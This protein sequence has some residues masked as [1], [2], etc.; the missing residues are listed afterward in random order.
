MRKLLLGDLPEPPSGKTGWPWTTQTVMPDHIDH[1]GTGLPII[2]IVTPSYNQGD[3]I[4]E[5]IRSVLLQNY[6]RID[7]IVIDGGSSDQSV[8]IIKKYEPWISYWRST[9]DGGQSDAINSGFELAEGS[10]GNWLNSDDILM[11]G[12]LYEVARVMRGGAVAAVGDSDYRIADWS[13][14]THIFESPPLCFDELFL[15]NAG[16]VIPQPSCFFRVDMFHDVGGLKPDLNLCMDLDLWFKL[17][18]LGKPERIIKCISWM[19]RHKNAKTVTAD[20]SLISEVEAVFDQ[21]LPEWRHSHP[22]ALEM[23]N[24]ERSEIAIERAYNDLQNKRLDKFVGSFAL[25]MKI[26]ARDTLNVRNT[27]RL[28][29]AVLP[30]KST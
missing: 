20:Q 10:L 15:Y 30:K 4:E 26:S 19:R 22:R 13:K 27:K 3:Y 23:L 29:R 8:E 6:P 14:V 18:R 24:K 16:V 2:S 21:H 28:L 11:P 7:Y 12:A 9:P 17:Y 5:T 25:A 1:V